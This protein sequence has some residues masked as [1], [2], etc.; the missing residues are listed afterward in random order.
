MTNHDEQRLHAFRT[1]ITSAQDLD[2]D[3]ARR[4]LDAYAGPAGWESEYVQV[5]SVTL[6]CNVRVRI[7]GRFVTRG[8]VAISEILAGMVHQDPFVAAVLQF[9]Y[10]PDQDLQDTDTASQ[11]APPPGPEVE[12][13][14][15]A[16][17]WRC[18]GAG[19]LWNWIRAR[20]D[21]SMV[22]VIDSVRRYGRGANYPDR[23]EDWDEAQTR[24]G[25][26]LAI[27]FFRKNG[28]NTDLDPPATD[29][30]K[31][32]E[33]SSEGTIFVGDPVTFLDD[34]TGEE[35]HGVVAEQ[36]KGIDVVPSSRIELSDGSSVWMRD[37]FLWKREDP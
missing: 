20:Q 18:P 32:L 33:P 28:V 30:P 9:G 11:P 19:Y 24:N 25:H 22:S 26:R 7:A 35:R 14:N 12:M 37:A 5:D 27:K 36:K 13:S 15:L 10:P 31:P 21:E 16:L 34:E 17:R 8:V 2:A 3:E 23:M 4:L 6:A 1:A 29:T